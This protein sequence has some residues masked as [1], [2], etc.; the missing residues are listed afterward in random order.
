[1]AEIHLKDIF[2]TYQN[3]SNAVENLNLKIKEGEF[4]TFV[5]PSG[6]GKTTTLRMIAGL[7]EI[8]SGELYINNVF[9]NY[10]LPKDR[11]IAMVFQSYA[12]FPHMTVESNIGFG[13]KIKKVDPKI[14]KEKVAKIIDLMGL[15]GLGNTKPGQLSGGQRQRVALGRAIILN[16]QVLL[17]DE[18]LSNLDAKLRVKMR[19]ELKRIHKR[20]NCTMVYV[21]HDQSE[22]MT[23]SDRI[24]IMNDG[25]LIQC[26][27]PNKV[28]NFP[29]NKFV[30]GFIGSPSMNFIDGEIKKEGE[31]YFFNYESG[32]CTISAK[33][34]YIIEKSNECEIT[35]GF[36]P[37]DGCIYYDKMENGIEGI[38]SVIETLGSD[39]YIDI[40]VAGEIVQIRISPENKY[41]M[42]KKVYITVKDEKLHFF[43][44]K[45]G[46]RLII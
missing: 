8:T 29:V 25:Q 41:D 46:I 11:D 2:K 4:V 1:M 10:M 14:R 27:T 3:H 33:Y 31:K 19:T 40:E 37:E 13:L 24:A 38:T 18:P 36:R 17:L 44:K 39:D 9:S 23:L 7:E 35:I 30:A 32:K 15:S 34:G 42:D 22:A 45:T 20:F 5:G 26:D 43:N 6:C 21:T 28:Y 12:L 16:P